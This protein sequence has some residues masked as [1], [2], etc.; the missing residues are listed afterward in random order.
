MRAATPTRAAAMTRAA[1]HGKRAASLALT[2]ITAAAANTT[3]AV[4]AAAATRARGSAQ[5]AA[6][7]TW[8]STHQAHRRRYRRRRRRRRHCRSRRATPAAS[9]CTRTATRTARTSGTFL[10]IRVVA[11]CWVPTRASARMRTG[12]SM[13][14]R[15][16]RASPSCAT[17]G[18]T[19]RL[20]RRLWRTGQRAATIRCAVSGGTRVSIRCSGRAASST[21]S[22][23]LGRAR[24]RAWRT[25]CCSC[26]SR[27]ARATP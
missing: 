5:L 11:R 7:P 21:R 16:P 17:T 12:S 19:T 10:W 2:A 3:R 8:V 22:T 14:S 26:A 23:L 20:L 25:A 18:R 9:T 4:V 15:A 1:R 24:T 6:T 13:V 27:R